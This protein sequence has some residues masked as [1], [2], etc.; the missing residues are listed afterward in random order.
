MGQKN[1]F[2]SAQAPNGGKARGNEETRNALWGQDPG[3]SGPTLRC[4]INERV[5][6]TT[7]SSQR[8][9]IT[10]SLQCHEAV[11][12]IEIENTTTRERGRRCR[13]FNAEAAT[14]SWTTN[15]FDGHDDDQSPRAERA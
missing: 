4:R 6:L 15:R 3:G 1:D 5:G 14:E 8:T 9:I 2:K 11:C 10:M 12:V 7:L 13:E